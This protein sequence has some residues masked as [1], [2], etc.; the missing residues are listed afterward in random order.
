MHTSHIAQ[1]FEFS[2]TRGLFSNRNRYHIPI[3]P[4]EICCVKFVFLHSVVLC[5]AVFPLHAQE[6]LDDVL[7]I[8]DAC[9]VLAAHPDDILRVAPGVQDDELVP[10][11]AVKACAA[12]LDSSDDIARHAFQLGRAKLELNDR[13]GAVDLFETS[14]EAGS[15]IAV[16]YL[17]DAQQFGWT[18]EPD[19]EAALALYEKSLDMGLLIANAAIDQ[20][21]F[22]PE[23]FTTGA[24]LE[25][26][27]DREIDKAASYAQSL[28]ARSYLYAFAVE[29]SDRCGSFLRPEAVPALQNYRFPPGWS[30]ASEEGEQ[31]LG[32]QD[33]NATYDVEVLTDRHGCEGYI[34]ETI[35]ASFND[36]LLQ[37][38]AGGE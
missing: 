33:V 2:T 9:D 3:L 4:A 25:V 19:P 22:D 16:M 36:M 6:G 34:V 21:Q 7:S 15:A 20:V 31:Q 28:L 37:L 1:N 18:G 32:V 24:M 11:L 27:A 29:L 13:Q 30:A 5:F 8:V 23:I 35:A 14:A 38:A 17:G 10:R 26:L 12:A